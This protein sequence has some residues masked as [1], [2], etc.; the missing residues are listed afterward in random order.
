ML[1]ARARIG[2]RKSIQ[3]NEKHSRLQGEKRRM[4][5]VF[6]RMTRRAIPL[7]GIAM[8]GMNVTVNGNGSC[9]GNVNRYLRYE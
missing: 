6:K 8:I 3:E 9:S 1:K 4:N 7:T 5:A 2:S